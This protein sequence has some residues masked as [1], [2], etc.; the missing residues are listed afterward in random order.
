MQNTFVGW[1]LWN[2]YEVLGLFQQVGDGT[3]W[4]SGPGPG[5]SFA[6]DITKAKP[7]TKEEV[8]GLIFNKTNIEKEP[9]VV[10]E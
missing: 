10:K 4:F 1:Y 7:A 6:V 2:L 8:I 5:M 9:G 3:W